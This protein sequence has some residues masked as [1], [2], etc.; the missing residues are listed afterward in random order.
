[1]GARGSLNNE[2]AQ[3]RHISVPTWNHIAKDKAPKISQSIIN[4]G[5]LTESWDMSQE[6]LCAYVCIYIFLVIR[7]IDAFCKKK[8][9]RIITKLQKSRL[10]H[11]STKSPSLSSLLTVL[12]RF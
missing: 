1:M 12:K 6:I 2:C 11:N 7:E 4:D 3:H 5:L 9:N 10:P 8:K